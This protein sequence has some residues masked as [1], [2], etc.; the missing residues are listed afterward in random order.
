ML[1]ADDVSTRDRASALRRCRERHGMPPACIDRRA[2]VIIREDSAFALSRAA[3]R[4]PQGS[5]LGRCYSARAMAWRVGVDVGG[6]FTDLAA[7]DDA[8]RAVRLEKVP[9]TPADQS[10]GVAAGLGALLARHG[11]ALAAV[12]YLGHGTTVCINAV[13][14]R[15]GARTGL[16]ITQGMRDLLELRR[17]IRD[18]LYDLQADKP[19]SAVSWATATFNFS[20]L[21]CHGDVGLSSTGSRS[22]GTPLNR[23]MALR[24]RS[25]TSIALSTSSGLASYPWMMRFRTSRN[26][27]ISPRSSCGK[28]SCCSRNLTESRKVERGDRRTQRPDRDDNRRPDGIGHELGHRVQGARTVGVAGH[29]TSSPGRR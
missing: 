14:E 16:V 21:R 11:V 25:P 27:S 17:Q 5:D 19:S 24:I 8:N 6:T 12:S 23:R 28:S 3:A 15:K 1:H 26:F 4:I 20:I 2:L 7:V 18:D 9:T 10:I 13:L 22:G 29:R